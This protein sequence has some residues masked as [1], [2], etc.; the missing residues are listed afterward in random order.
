MI[1]YSTQYN[2]QLISN[3]GYE[4]IL[5]NI[6]FNEIKKED[7]VYASTF[8]Y[9][10]S[11]LDKHLKNVTDP[12]GISTEDVL[13]GDYY[14][15]EYYA[16]LSDNLSILYNLTEVMEKNY[17]LLAKNSNDVD[18]IIELALSLP[19]FLF[20]TYNLNMTAK[21]EYFFLGR[22][23]YNYKLQIEKLISTNDFRNLLNLVENNYV[24]E[25]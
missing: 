12:Q 16:L 3:L 13:L 9:A 20:S 8:I 1:N 18:N 4:N 2:E 24:D 23:F 15:F 22:F 5:S 6:N 21:I 7:V 10:I 11:A 25:I 19:R 14:S 17:I